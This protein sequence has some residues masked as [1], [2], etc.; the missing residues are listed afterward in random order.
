MFTARFVFSNRFNIVSM[1]RRK[2]GDFC[3]V[4]NAKG[5]YLVSFDVWWLNIK[6]NHSESKMYEEDHDPQRTVD[7]GP[8][9]TMDWGFPQITDY[10]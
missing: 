8:Q 10:H 2:K 3:F 1:N 4:I 9:P 6:N 7:H 5:T